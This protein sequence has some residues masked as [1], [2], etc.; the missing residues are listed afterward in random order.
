[1]ISRVFSPCWSWRSAAGV[2]VL[3][4]AN[5]GTAAPGVVTSIKPLQLI[6]AAVTDGVSTPALAI[7]AGQDPHHL[8]LRPSERRTMQDAALVLWVGPI[9]ELPLVDV[10]EGLEA[11]VVTSQQLS[12][13]KVEQV[14]G[15]A[16][17]HIWLDSHNARH[18]ASALA[19]ELQEMDAINADRYARNAAAFSVSL[20]AVDVEID[21]ALHAIQGRAWAVSHHAFRY[22][23]EQHHLQEPLAL[24]DSSNNAPGVKSVLALREQLAAQHIACLLT[25][26]TENHQQ[27][28]ALLSGSN[29]NVVSADVLGV[30]I[31][32]AADAYAQ[33]LRQLTTALQECMGVQP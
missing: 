26:P 7:G 5:A 33:L 18:I 16:D 9:L 23:A 8:S 24:T 4:A 20:D 21:Q 28:D 22:F 27:L 15:A 30:A 25:E 11:R 10:V 14:D 1:M 13:M 17:P 3:L 29:I 2:I 32:P 6:A 12:G 19:A 31:A